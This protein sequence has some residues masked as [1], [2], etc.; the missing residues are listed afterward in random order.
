MLILIWERV[1]ILHIDTGTDR[2]HVKDQG[3]LVRDKRGWTMDTQVLEFKF[4]AKRVE[5][6]YV[7]TATYV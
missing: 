7:V 5:S 4:F 2:A 6:S 1:E 3:G